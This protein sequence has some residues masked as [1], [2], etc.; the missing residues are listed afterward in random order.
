MIPLDRGEPGRVDVASVSG[1]D[2]HDDTLGAG[3]SQPGHDCFA[4]C[5][6]DG[7][8]ADDQ[9]RGVASNAGGEKIFEAR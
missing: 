4:R 5:H 1:L 8:D 6:V 7:V 9:E 2:R 3:K